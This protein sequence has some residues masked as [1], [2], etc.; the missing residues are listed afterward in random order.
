MLKQIYMMNISISDGVKFINKSSQN[1][2]FN[3][4]KN[5]NLI[6]TNLT[7]IREHQQKTFVTLSRFWPLRGWGFE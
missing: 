6:E 5:M 1:F 7:Y 4:T 2:C 3:Y